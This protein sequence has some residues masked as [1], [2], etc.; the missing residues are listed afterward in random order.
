MTV[1]DT[2]VETWKAIPG[3][4]FYEASDLGSVRSIDRTE[5]ATGRRLPSVVL[6]TRVSNSGY[7][8]V[9]LRDADG[10]TQ[11]RTV[12][13]LVM[14]AFAGPCPAGQQTRHL[15]D[16]PL[17]N[18]WPE[19][20]CYG[21]REENQAD[22]RVNRPPAPPRPVRYCACGNQVTK[23]GRRCH[24]CVVK[25]GVDATVLLRGGMTL[26]DVNERLGYGNAAYLHTLAV[27]YGG[28]GFLPQPSRG[29]MATLR[30]R[31]RR[32]DAV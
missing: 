1:S 9:N 27:K 17:D 18:R 31:L 23:G 20:L 14:L 29:V 32:G 13:R 19:N 26:D 24:D 5:A 12:H 16:N 22:K 6:K 2:R 25:L 15:N 4:P 8:L 28:W 10:K 30:A 11:T 21:T 3:Y 7:V